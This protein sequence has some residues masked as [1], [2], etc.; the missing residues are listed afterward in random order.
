[1][2]RRREPI[3]RVVDWQVPDDRAHG[4]DAASGTAVRAR[5]AGAVVAAATV[6]GGALVV[7]AAVGWWSGAETRRGQA[8]AAAVED[9]FGALNVRD[10]PT[11]LAGGL[12]RIDRAGTTWGF[13]QAL[14]RDGTAPTDATRDGTL[15]DARCEPAAAGIVRCH[16]R[17]DGGL[18]DAAGVDTRAR[19]YFLVADDGVVRRAW[20]E[21]L[22]DEQRPAE[23]LRELRAWLA[24]EH[25]ATLAAVYDTDLPPLFRR[26]FQD[27]LA[28]RA[29][30]EAV[31]DGFLAER[32]RSLSD[33]DG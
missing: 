5:R 31:L 10:A 15:V 19:G 26:A 25:P 30:V 9:L 28:N 24:A 13:L 2:R 11:Y 32:G 27:D 4:P 33:D 1:M 29:R 21:L 12:H 6:L 14:P 7:N 17:Q 3:E 20:I 8:Q 23:L 18:F 16:L 22:A